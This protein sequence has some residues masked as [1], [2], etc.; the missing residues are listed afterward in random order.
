MKIK[1]VTIA[2]FRG[3]RKLDAPVDLS[4]L[5]FFIGDNGTG[6]TS[7]LEAINLCLSSG[8]V[9]SRLDVNDFHSGSDETIEVVVEFVQPVTIKIP[10]GFATQD[11]ACNKVV[12]KAKKRDRAAPGKAFSDLVT[13][14]QHFVPVEARG[15]KGWSK[16]RKNGSPFSFDERQLAVSNVESDLPRVFFFG[17]NR[18][19]QLSKGFNSSLSSIID[20]LN[21]RFDRGQRKKSDED[22]FKHHRKMLHDIVFGETEGETLK[23]TIEAANIILSKL[24]VDPVEF[25]LLKTLNPYDNSEI[26][27]AFDGFE[28]PAEHGG[29]GVEMLVSLALLEALA[30]LSKEKLIILIDEPELHLHPKLQAR[31]VEHLTDLSSNVQIIASTHS[32]LLF[33]NVFRHPDAKL[34][35]TKRETGA[36]RVVD[37][38]SAGFGY[39]GWSP[40]WGEICYFAYGLPTV[41]FHDDLYGALEDRFRGS[42]TTK[43]SQ[44]DFDMWLV[45]HGHPQDMKWTGGKGE[46]RAETLMTYVRN[47][48]HHPENHFRPDY[49]EAQLAASI[50]GMCNLIKRLA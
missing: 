34:Q 26:V 1:C 5:N 33:K 30:L 6:K 50:E 46:A 36:V 9:A 37:A 32:P 17:K 2:N 35:I 11:V 48:I 3:I 27:F 20:D 15:E 31:L 40:S 24:G 22:H 41:E 10:D 21:W 19:R 45:G 18:A 16:L 39:L 42:P 28:L 43:T 7:L 23:K 29:S 49:T 13:T 8:Y 38:H 47:R 4:D 25:S 14:T 44:A 12:L